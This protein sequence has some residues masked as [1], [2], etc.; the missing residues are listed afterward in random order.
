MCHKNNFF[1]FLAPILVPAIFVNTKEMTK[2][3]KEN[4]IRSFLTKLVEDAIHY[5]IYMAWTSGMLS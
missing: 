5:A 2:Y 1:E 4:D 3:T